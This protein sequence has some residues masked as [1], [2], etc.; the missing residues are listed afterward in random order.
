MSMS[1]EIVSMLH[2]LLGTLEH[3]RRHSK[4]TQKDRDVCLFP[5]VFIRLV[6]VP[7]ISY[8]LF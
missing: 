2:A 6:R 1:M 5:Q 3:C 8:C 7:F 4:T